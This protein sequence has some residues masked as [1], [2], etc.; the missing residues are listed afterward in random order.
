[1]AFKG[2]VFIEG[3]DGELEGP[4][5]NGSCLIYEFDHEVYL[6]FD[7]ETNKIQGSRRLKAISITKDI[8]KLTPTLAQYCCEGTELAKVIIVLYKIKP[9]SSSEVPYFNFTL[10][11]ARIV[12]VNTLMPTTKKKENE[13]VGHL[14]KIKFLGKI[15]TWNFDPS[16]EEGKEGGA[17]TYQEVSF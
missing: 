2:E 15:F 17:P 7:M 1:M 4:R 13:N 11:E 10:E 9:E 16:D 3:P 8:D 5:E 14:E 12:Q 6:P